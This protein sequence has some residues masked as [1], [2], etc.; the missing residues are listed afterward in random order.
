MSNTEMSDFCQ[1]EHDFS[2]FT[3]STLQFL[4]ETAISKV[5]YDL[6]WSF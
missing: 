5:K 6:C 1:F 3:D 4:T 2:G